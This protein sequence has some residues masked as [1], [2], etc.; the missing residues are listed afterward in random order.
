MCMQLCM[1]VCTF[2]ENTM[3]YNYSLEYLILQR[4]YK[5]FEDLADCSCIV[6]EMYT[7][8]LITKSTMEKICSSSNCSVEKNRYL[9]IINS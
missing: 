8:G 5:I 3:S 7:Y 1:Y 2:V 4:Y 9:L 6:K